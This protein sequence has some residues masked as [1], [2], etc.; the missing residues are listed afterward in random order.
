MMHSVDGRRTNQSRDSPSY[1]TLGPY[2]MPVT[3]QRNW[4]GLK[5]RSSPAL[6]TGL[7]RYTWRGRLIFVL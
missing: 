4:G 2:M 5:G 3:R 7:S 1:R 6:C